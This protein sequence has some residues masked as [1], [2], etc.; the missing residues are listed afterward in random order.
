VGSFTR[1]ARA[2]KVEHRNGRLAERFKAPVLEL[3]RFWRA[4]GALTFRLVRI[5]TG[6]IEHAIR[7]VGRAV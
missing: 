7:K 5:K 1:F 2:R 3:S 4:R 6:N